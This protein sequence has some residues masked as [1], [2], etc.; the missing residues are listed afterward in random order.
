[1]AS[2]F[3]HPVMLSPGAAAQYNLDPSYYYKMDEGR[4]ILR[5]IIEGLK[6]LGYKF[7]SIGDQKIFPQSFPGVY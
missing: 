5:H 7:V 3:W 2:F 6:G 4:G 1:M